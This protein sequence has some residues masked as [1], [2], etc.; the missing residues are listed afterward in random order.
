MKTINTVLLFMLLVFALVSC[1]NGR[2]ANDIL[3]DPEQRE[4]VL[5]AIANDSTLLAK[6]H[7]KMRSDGQAQMHAT[8]PMMRSCV[9][10]MNNPEMMNMMMDNRGMMSM[11]MDNMMMRSEEDSA[12]CTMMCDKMM[13]SENLRNMMHRRMNNMNMKEGGG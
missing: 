13:S 1:S 3:N 5:T 6:L 8:H 9:A 7:D 4:E 11:M 12:M 2:S 10:M